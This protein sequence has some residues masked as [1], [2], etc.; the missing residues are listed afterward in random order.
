MTFR[1]NSKNLQYTYKY[2]EENFVYDF[3][4]EL[5]T[6]IITEYKIYGAFIKLHKTVNKLKIQLHPFKNVRP[7]IIIP[8]C[9]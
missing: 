1:K 2:N 9:K 8:L 4:L 3:K 5:N 7:N 6:V